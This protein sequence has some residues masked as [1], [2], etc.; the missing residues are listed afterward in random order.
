V[1]GG[2]RFDVL[3]N[4]LFKLITTFLHRLGIYIKLPP[5]AGMPEVVVNIMVELLF[6]LALV[7][8]QTRQGPLSESLL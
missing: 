2:G 1:R 3:V 5:I 4:N 6:T 8:K 7:A